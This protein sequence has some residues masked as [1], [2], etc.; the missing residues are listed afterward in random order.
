[1]ADYVTP[2]Q[3]NQTLD[4]AL[5]KQ[6]REITQV[7][8]DMADIFGLQLQEMRGDINHLIGV[9]DGLVGRIDH[10]ETEDAARDA[11]ALRHEGWIERI[12]RTTDTRL[13]G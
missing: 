5:D 7:I 13:E 4:R 10:Y 9:V 6:T 12:A 3:L 1:M 11:R 2:K 8:R